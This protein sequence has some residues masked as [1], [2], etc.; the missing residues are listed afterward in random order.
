M[1]PNGIFSNNSEPVSPTPPASPISPTPSAPISP[2]GDII[3]GGN[4][5]KKKSKKPLIITIFVAIFIAVILVVVV[6]LKQGVL[7]KKQDNVDLIQN[8]TDEITMNWSGGELKDT[9]FAIRIAESDNPN[10]ITAYYK[11]LNSESQGYSENLQELIKVLNYT[12][13]Y[14]TVRD[15][16]DSIYSEKGYDAAK[17]MI[18]NFKYS[19][20]D[21][22]LKN[23]SDT[24]IQYYTNYLSSYN[25]LSKS[26]CIKT[27]SLDQE[28]AAENEIFSHTAKFDGEAE[29]A[30]AYMKDADILKVLNTI[31]LN[32][33]SQSKKGNK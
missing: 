21:T 3:L 8:G 19:G 11:I 18:N 30:L 13:N 33:I 24:Y 5:P 17:E 15:D 29:D 27:G 7:S 25:L 1:D 9:V 32:T 6:L 26:G 20:D 10:Q 2:A 12:I 16:L 31:V 4:N 22:F 14:R 23:M 28:C